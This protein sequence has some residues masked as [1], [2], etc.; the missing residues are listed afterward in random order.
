MALNVSAWSIRNPVP[1]LVLFTVL[2]FLGIW[3]L[4]GLPITRFP[5]V[6]IP[7][8]SVTVTQGGTA[9]SELEGQV[10]KKI[11]DAVA[12][13]AGIK[14]ISSSISEGLST[15]TIEFRLETKSDRA[16]NDVKDAVARVRSDL[17]RG[18]DEPL[19]QRVDVVGLPIL[20]YAVSSPEMSLEDLSWF[21]DDVVA[22]SLQNIRGVGSVNRIGGVDR[23]IRITLDPDRLIALG[24]TSADVSR[25][26]RAINADLA[27]G[28]GGVSGQEQSIRILGGAR[29]IEE[30]NNLSI[31][32]SGGRKVRL[33]ELAS[34]TDGAAE[35]RRFA[36]LDG[37]PVVAI[38]ISRASGASD[39]TVAEQVATKVAALNKSYPKTSI[40]LIDTFVTY[41]VGNFESAM[42][43]LVEGALLSVLVVLL[44]LRNW[45]ATLITAIALP[46]SILP[47]FWAIDALGFS[48]NLVSLLALT[49]A[50]GILVDD[51][52]VEIENIVR[53][54]HMGKSA[55]RAA[56]EAADEIGLAVIAISFT[57]VAV[58][59]P[60]SFMSGIAGQY[61][62]Q[63]GLTIAIAVLFSLTVARLL[64]PLLAAYFLRPEPHKL[65]QGEGR[66]MQGYTKIV[67]FSVRYRF[68]T[69]IA[70]AMIFALS[71]W[72]T[73]FLPSGFMPGEDVARLLLA[74][75]LPPGSPVSQ[76]MRVT[77]TIVERLRQK[78]EI[79]SIF[80]DGGKIG[81]GAAEVRKAQ[82]VIN[83]VHK[84]KRDKSQKQIQ[85]EIG[86][87]LAQVPD[88]R[89]WFLNDNG[90]R[91]VSLTL[92][93]T[94][95][96]AVERT[97]ALLQSQ[98]KRIPIISNVVSTASLDRPEI[99][100]K[101]DFDRAAE[102]GVSSEALA[103]TIRVATIGDTDANLA[104]F[105][106]GNRLIPIRVE[107]PESARGQVDILANLKL[108]TT[109]GVTVPLSALAE[110]QFSQ[111]P[112]SISR[113]DRVRRI[114]VE[115]DLSGTDALGEA[116]KAVYALPAA[117]NL[118]PGV[119]LKES[120]DAEIMVE[121][122]QGFADA[123]TAG[124]MMVLAV[125]VLLFSS[126]V[127]PITILLSLP[128]SIGGV[129]FALFIT[130][131]A[132]SM[133]VVIGILMLMG[134]V[135][136]NAIMLVD[137]ALERMADGMNRTEAIIDAGRKRA[138]P[139]VMTTIAMAA[140]MMPSAL[141]IGDGGEFRSPMAIGVIG[142]LL[143]STILSLVF[144]PAAFTILDDIG[145]LASRLF[146]GVIGPK[147]EP[148]SANTQHETKKP[149][150]IAAE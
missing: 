129:I 59:A 111:G 72:A 103:E 115:A 86:D 41:T 44:F 28:R 70:G 74:V 120:G 9:P 93:G 97:G 48:L 88:I 66:I 117:Q 140:G 30:L 130:N 22:R 138:R 27:G 124:L 7:V 51:A 57:I 50:T 94:D 2:T 146:S 89:S 13:I 5:N 128:L 25:Q 122:F 1:G 39:A 144:V 142:G 114:A 75:E 31:S 71:L 55:Y 8:I 132:V 40:D 99:R 37:K 91:A 148:D 77:D 65:D 96:E 147:D 98:M 143:V 21:A 24:A 79:K 3:S 26:L 6:D 33:S 63:F 150:R 106:A 67:A 12:G 109:R 56:L 46:L 137:F 107:L 90:M 108:T 61:F 20:T 121:V 36:R 23:E 78:P 14:H 133:P 52:I 92:S 105:N 139:I 104:K 18:I 11:E 76:T 112:T 73:K 29:K 85:R 134:I 100:I 83:L 58:F 16:L 125:L 145:R 81:L 68:V 34:V 62:K 149:L 60:V 10:S 135:T 116:L 17:P 127:Q 141:G 136:K 82:L 19:V 131:K 119:T 87:E 32:L 95:N 110:F 102:L 69:I 35:Q 54:M 45:R 123:M 101:P 49:L 4:M 113:Y 53:H 38:A 64:T 43:T 47:T 118:P 80:I 15:T 84:T 42:H 126:I